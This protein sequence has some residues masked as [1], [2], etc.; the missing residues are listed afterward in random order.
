MVSCVFM[1]WV[2]DKI[3]WRGA[4]KL[5]QISLLRSC[6]QKPCFY[7]GISNRSAQYCHVLLA[8]ITG[9]EVRKVNHVPMWT[10]WWLGY[11]HIT[12][13]GQPP[14]WW[15]SALL[16]RT[17]PVFHHPRA[18][19]SQIRVRR[20]NLISTTPRASHPGTH[21]LPTQG[22]RSLVGSE[23]ASLAS[24]HSDALSLCGLGGNGRVAGTSH[25]PRSSPQVTVLRW[26]AFRCRAICHPTRKQTQRM[27]AT[28]SAALAQWSYPNH[29]E[30][31]T[32]SCQE[33]SKRHGSFNGSQCK[34][35]SDFCYI[36][37][38]DFE[39]CKAL[40]SLLTFP[41]H[42]SRTKDCCAKCM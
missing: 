12:S 15:K 22:H 25:A 14:C 5:F 4:H 34:L 26:A 10:L 42:L 3:F 2:R 16:Q 38:I 33:Q 7:S 35:S 24:S 29:M 27:W 21:T 30:E 28:A 41:L 36:L 18:Q 23:D 19:A 17:S 32:F 8:L 39:K 40:P 11:C 13:G 20:N 6:L 37:I 9:G 31:I 1:W